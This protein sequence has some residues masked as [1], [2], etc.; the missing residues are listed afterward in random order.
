MLQRPSARRFSIF[1]FAPILLFVAAVLAPLRPAPAAAQAKPHG[2]HDVNHWA[3]V[4]ESPE[5]AKWQKPGQVVAALKIKPGQSVAD[6]G[7]GTG[8]FTRRFAAAV[9]P[10]GSAIGLDI[11]PAMVAYMKQ[12]AARRHLSNYT[13]SVSQPGDA[14]LAPHSIDL[15]FFCDVYHHVPDRIAY[16][17]KLAPALK[18][19][20]RIALID[21]HHDAPVG[22]PAKIRIPRTQA[23]AEFREA[24]YRLTGSH[25][26]LPYQYFLE[27]QPV[28]TDTQP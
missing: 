1:T 25:D 12:D 24:G 3:K 27:F 9:G 17:K 16:L 10:T 19:K 5:R 18:P 15:I 23:I 2:F 6:I 13:A 11:E 26:F 21:F 14:G 8:Y 28:G 4:F 20:G 22:P 7:A